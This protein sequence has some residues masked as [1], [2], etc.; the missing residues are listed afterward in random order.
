MIPLNIINK[1]IKV[2]KICKKEAKVS[3]FTG[4][5]ILYKKNKRKDKHTFG[6]NFICQYIATNCILTQ[7]QNY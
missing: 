7:P 2:N 5:I 6:S 3:L 4:N 1:L